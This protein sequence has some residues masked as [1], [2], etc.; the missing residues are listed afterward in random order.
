MSIQIPAKKQVISH[1]VAVFLGL[2]GGF[3]GKDLTGLQK[4]AERAAE[5]AVDAAAI[6]VVSEVEKKIEAPK[7]TETKAVDAGTVIAPLA[8]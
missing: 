3:L 6:K 2:L 1:L 4:P 5:V 8:P 7:P